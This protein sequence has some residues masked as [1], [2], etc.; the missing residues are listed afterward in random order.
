MWFSP[1]RAA[2]GAFMAETQRYVTGEV[3][4]R[5]A[6][7]GAGA[8]SGRR[9]PVGLYDHGLATYDA[10]DAFHHEDAAGFIRLFG[11]GVQTWAQRQGVERAQES[12]PGDGRAPGTGSAAAAGPEAGG[13]DAG[14]L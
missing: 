4:C 9:S 14:A 2:L 1:L 3:R 12:V 10:A 11:L 13:G 8:V 5:F 6:P 7:G